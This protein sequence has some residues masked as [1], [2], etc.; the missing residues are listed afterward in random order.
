MFVSDSQRWGVAAVVAI[1]LAFYGAS[2][3]RSRLAPRENPLPWGD[4]TEDTLAVEV[5]NGRGQ[6]GVYFLREKTRAAQLGEIMAISGAGE[7]RLPEVGPILSGSTLSVSPKGEVRVGEMA[8]ARKL[9]LGL[10]LDLNRASEA[11][12]ALVPGI[13]ERMAF[14]IVAL[15]HETGPFRELSALTVVPGIKEKKLKAIGRYLTIGRT[16]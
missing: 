11:D 16:P 3:F 13:G 2:E 5:S 6:S 8:A 7:V 12:L 15:R 14:S 9:A 1:S 10:P 4:Q